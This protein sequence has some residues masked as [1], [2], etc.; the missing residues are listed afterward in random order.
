MVARVCWCSVI[1]DGG[2]WPWVLL[3]GVVVVLVIGGSAGFLNI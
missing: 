1:G 3:G 2:E